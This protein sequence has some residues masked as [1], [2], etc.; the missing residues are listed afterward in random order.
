MESFHVDLTPLVE[1]AAANTAFKW[2]SYVTAED[3]AQELWIWAYSR[4]NSIETAMRDGDWEAKVYSTMLKAA[5]EAAS[6]ED[7]ATN[8]Y[9]KDDTYVYSKAVI[10]TLLDSAFTYEDWQSFGVF[11]DGQPSA[12][13]QVNETGDV[14]AMLSDVKAA[15]AEVKKEYRE[16][17]FLRHAEQLTDEAIG[18]RI[19]M[20]R[21][22][23]NNRH[24]RA[25]NAVRD[26]LGRIN[27][28]DLRQDAGDRYEVMGNAQANAITD[29][30]YEG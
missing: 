26:V 14:V 22:G 15:L 9:S 1:R 6:K 12:K 13:G 16:V 25:I 4:Q 3:V 8:G 30:L 19:G 23:A 5:S 28:A 11:G 29:R 2:P 17:L 10:E 21:T 24:T 20:T 27:I 7:R 18:A